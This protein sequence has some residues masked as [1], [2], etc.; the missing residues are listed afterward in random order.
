MLEPTGGYEIECLN[1]LSDAQLAVA[2]INARQIRDFAQSCGQI[3]KT[4]SIDAE[5]IALFAQANRPP[6]RPYPTRL[7]DNSKRWWFGGGSWWNLALRSLRARTSPL[8]LSAL[9]SV[10]IEH[11]SQQIAE[12]DGQIQGLLKQNPS[13]HKHDELLPP[14]HLPPST[15]VGIRP[16]GFTMSSLG[17]MILAIG[18]PMRV[19]GDKL[20]IWRQPHPRR[21]TCRRCWLPVA[22]STPRMGNV[23]HVSGVLRY[24]VRT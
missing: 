1:A 20:D 11:L 18:G 3:A 23:A 14:I 6:V 22:R 4:D 7:S 24:G 2:L 19:T 17:P 21:E 12:L 16:H 5:I 9:P 10:L 15:S 13:W 8:I